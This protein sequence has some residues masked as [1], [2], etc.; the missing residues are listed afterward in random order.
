M[1]DLTITPDAAETLLENAEEKG[2]SENNPM[3]QEFQEAVEDGEQVQTEISDQVIENVI[4]S[5][6]E[7]EDFNLEELESVSEI[8]DF[9]RNRIDRLQNRYECDEISL[10][11]LENKLE[12]LL[13]E[14][15]K[16]EE[17]I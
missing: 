1:R 9:Y 13:T 7:L 16:H 17:N 15:M 2:I 12:P 10:L 5:S 4:A 14:L 8:P 11:E 6:L 3:Y